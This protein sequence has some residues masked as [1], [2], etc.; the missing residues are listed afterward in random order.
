[1]NNYYRI[2]GYHPTEDFCFIMDC[3]GLYEKMW[4]FS[5]LL[6]QKG[7]KV[8]E[9]SNQDTFIDINIKP[10]EKDNE[11]IALRAIM[12]GKPENIIQEYHGKKYNAI[13]VAEYI[14]IPNL[15]KVLN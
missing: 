2:T 8:L 15:T 10:I 9:V 14:Y 13:K 3:F 1:M 7:L 6:I 11:H 4:Q 12:Q 5:S